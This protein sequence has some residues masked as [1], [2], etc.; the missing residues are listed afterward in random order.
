ML[1]TDIWLTQ[2]INGAAGRDPTLDAA[3]M[4]FA[5]WSI[6]VLV[7]GVA[8][9]WW[10]GLPRPRHRH[11]LVAAGLSFMLALAIN[12]VIL[13]FLHRPR[14]YELGLTHL[15]GSPSS[16]PSFPSDHAA[17]SFAIAGA[18]LAHRAFGRASVFILA[19]LLVSFS[20]VFIGTHYVSDV[21][22]GALIGLASAFAVRLAY[23][24]DTKFDRLVTEIL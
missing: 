21:F 20:R 19:A 18:F 3:M 4:T 17:A 23:Q 24:P 7:L 1:Q 13:L 6:P 2:L 16:D 10:S 5:G 12:Q 22:G 8:L 11:I 15:L 9:Q 14:P